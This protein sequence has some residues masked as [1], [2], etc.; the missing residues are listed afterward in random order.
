M[1]KIALNNNANLDLPNSW[2]D[3]TEEQL[4]FTVKILML[5]YAGK[6]TPDKARIEMLINYTGYR[7]DP[8]IT[9]R[10]TINFNLIRLSELLTFAFTVEEN[11]ITPQ[12]K[13][14]RNPLP[15]LTIGDILYTGKK[16]NLDITAKTDIIAREFIDAFDLLSALAQMT[17][18]E[19]KELCLNQLCAILYPAEMTHHQNLVSRQIENMRQVS[20]PE[21]TLI[22]YWFTGVVHYYTTH[23]VYSL[24]FSGTKKDSQDGKISLGMNE[25]ALYLK[26]EGY[27]DPETMNLNDYFD[28][29][30]KSLK[31]TISRALAE[32]VKIEKIAEKTGLSNAIIHKLS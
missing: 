6:I 22:L 14:K 21:K 9:D 24:L 2:E 8:K 1:K 13:F 10:D 11:T 26:K 27:G 28:A 3:L 32:G 7:P 20:F 23:H 4:L 12:F 15:E 17:E 30:I 31:D 5:L 19:R 16:F 18:P 29:Q 25:V